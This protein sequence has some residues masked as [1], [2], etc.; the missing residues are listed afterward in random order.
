MAT[1]QVLIEFIAD[2][3][4]LESSIDILTKMGEIDEKTASAFKEG[5]KE[6]QKRADVVDKVADSTEGATQ[7]TDKQLKSANDL[8]KGVDTLGSALEEAFNK[9]LVDQMN[10]VSSGMDALEKRAKATGK[11]ILEV[12]AA[13]EQLKNK[14]RESTALGPFQSLSKSVSDAEKKVLSLAARLN[15]LTSKGITSG[16]LYD[17]LTKELP[18]AQAELKK[19]KTQ[20][21][22]VTASTK[23][24]ETATAGFASS[25]E[26]L[27]T[28]LRRINQE[29]GEMIMRGEEGSQKFQELTKRA[30]EIRLAMSDAADAIN[31][32]GS[33]TS[34]L[35]RML[36]LTK[37]ITAGFGLAAGATML[38][39]KQNEDLQK[40]L[41]KVAGAMFILQSLQ[42]I[43]E[44]LNKK[45]TVSLGTLIGARTRDAA[46]TAAQGT[47]SVAATGATQGLTVA[48]RILNAV[49]KANPI[50]LLVAGI[51]AAVTAIA[52][53]IRRTKDSTREMEENT[54]AME[55]SIQAFERWNKLA[56]QSGSD[57]E[58]GRIQNL[59]D[60]IALLESQGAAQSKLS[61]LT[62]QL[63]EEEAKYAE[64]QLQDAEKLARAQLPIGILLQN[65][66]DAVKSLGQKMSL[67]TLDIEKYDKKRKEGIK[68]SEKEEKQLEVLNSRYNAFATLLE[69]ITGLR[70]G[71]TDAQTALSQA[72]YDAQKQAAEQAARDQI[73]LADSMLAKT[74]AGS[75][76]E[77]DAKNALIKAQMQSELSN[78]ELTQIQRQA[79]IDKANRQ[80]FENNQ[81]FQ[82]RMHEQE[83]ALLKVTNAVKLRTIAEG[84]ADELRLRLTELE[85]ERDL[86][87]KQAK[88]DQAALKVIN[89][90]YQADKTQMEIDFAKK[91]AQSVLEV[92]RLGLQMRI[93][94]VVAGTEEELQLRQQ[95]IDKQKEIEIAAM[96]ER[97]K[98]TEEGKKKI[99]QIL[100]AGQAE[101]VK[102]QL[103][104][105]L[106][107]V[108]QNMGLLKAVTDA[109]I[110]EN[111]RVLASVKATYAERRRA[112]RDI[113]FTV[114]DRVEREKQAIADRIK[115][116]EAA[117]KKILGVTELTEA[118]K[119]AIE[120]KYRT[121]LIQLNDEAQ[122]AIFDNE[123][124][125]LQRSME[126]RRKLME[127]TFT[128]LKASLD[129][130][131]PT[132]AAHTALSQILDVYKQIDEI[133]KNQDL[134]AQEKQIQMI[135]AAA[136]AVQA[137]LNQMFADQATQRQQQMQAELS[138]LD[139][140]KQRE[141]SNKNLTENQKTE[142]EKR[143]AQRAR[144][145]KQ[146]AWK[147]DQQA[148][149][150]QAIM[151]GA[152]AVLNALA[153]RPFIPAGLIA[154]GVA[155]AMTAAQV[156]VIGQQRM[157]QFAK[158]T[159]NAPR[160]FALVG[161]K[162]PEIVFMQG[163][164]RV[165]TH[166]E[167]KSIM[168]GWKQPTITLPQT[169][170]V[171]TNNTTMPEFDYERMGKEVAKNIPQTGLNVD[172]NGFKAWVQHG[173]NRIN[174]KNSRYSL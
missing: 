48:T 36:D 73:A 108:D 165:Y 45:N 172:E 147:A 91:S 28:E 130:T 100:N 7:A 30:G 40:V 25:Q 139:E 98:L 171:V 10:K 24:T 95:M 138:R 157:P 34:G 54:K 46:A 142:I 145:E 81:A 32:A 31:R 57:K 9:Q 113:L 158:G 126:A 154:A 112:E 82:L 141:L 173:S 97:V 23:A 3:S 33:V 105:D 129:A 77:L 53:F 78:T 162:G 128:M 64:K 39:G 66:G 69:K 168:G 148:A 72:M 153:T 29:M 119:K 6:L 35:D 127:D 56:Q 123:Q 65:Q 117:V 13:Q 49:M 156:A 111:Q 121:E 26:N 5:N 4:G 21:D 166:T 135:G 38:F 85:K 159:K 79:I 101:K 8:A 107:D 80:I 68:L 87:I 120:D 102:L 150:T 144:Q 2:T 88:G 22:Q 17:R 92:Q 96:D 1:E 75:K 19:L 104:F 164:E 103:E 124:K 70:Q 60:T 149:K 74:I 16:P 76:K 61:D 14:L 160:G 18:Q 37:G 20:Y 93:D 94:N 51:T 155:T 163:G 146:R 71:I 133:S 84:S 169:S 11:T 41:Q 89:A 62:R 44:L 137:T 47:A 170:N 42:Q 140:L 118:Q 116:E 59:K 109:E 27:R 106:K 125:W 67:L 152:I 136:M 161:E 55:A 83:V 86:K 52:F 131:L 15:T 43:Q 114:L 143:Y 12:A 90:Q 50:G 63:R 151:N 132:D 58:F 122:Q 110:N 167:T 174:F 99:E 115:L 134:S